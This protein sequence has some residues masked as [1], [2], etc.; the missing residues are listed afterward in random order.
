MAKNISVEMTLPLEDGAE[1]LPELEKEVEKENKND[2]DTLEKAAEIVGDINE[3]SGVEVPKEIPIRTLTEK[4]HLSE[5]LEEDDYFDFVHELA[6]ALEKVCLKWVK[7][8]DMDEEDVARAI[9][10]ASEKLIDGSSWLFENRETEEINNLEEDFKVYSDLG[11]FKPWSGAVD[12]WDRIEEADKLDELD[13]L[14]EEIY[15]EGLDETSLNDLLWYEP[16]WILE[17][18]GIDTEEE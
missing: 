16:E 14:L 6:Q 9:S 3:P 17:A 2:T 1:L 10:E 15:P 11:S 7:Y 18:L 8:T 5:E 12:T 4:L 13:A